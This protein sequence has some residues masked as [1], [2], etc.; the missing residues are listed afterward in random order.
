[1]KEGKAMGPD[2]IPIEVW[3]GLRDI[4]I[5]WITYLFILIFQENKMPEEWR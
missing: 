1:M 5:L 4:G 2:C 3:R